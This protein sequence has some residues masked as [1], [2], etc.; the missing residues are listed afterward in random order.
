MKT[1][2]LAKENY[3]YPNTKQINLILPSCPMQKLTQNG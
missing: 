2:D 1:E 3:S